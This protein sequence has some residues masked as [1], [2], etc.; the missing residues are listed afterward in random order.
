MRTSKSPTTWALLAVV[1][2]AATT[3]CR[4]GWGS[5]LSSLS[6][7]KPSKPPTSLSGQTLP[8]PSATVSSSLSNGDRYGNTGSSRV[9]NNNWGQVGDQNNYSQIPQTADTRGL[10]SDQGYASRTG[11]TSSTGYPPS[12]G[13]TSP[14]GNFTPPSSGYSSQTDYGQSTNSGYAPATSFTPPEGYTSPTRGYSPP[15]AVSSIQGSPAGLNASASSFTPPNSNGQNDTFG[16]RYG[17]SGTAT[18]PNVD[19]G[20]PGGNSNYPDTSNFRPELGTKPPYAPG[21]IGR[22][23]D[24]SRPSTAPAASGGYSNVTPS[25]ASTSPYGAPNGFYNTGGT[26]LYGNP[27]SDFGSDYNSDYS[28]PRQ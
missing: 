15:P 7:K 28:R 10:A 18:L 13:I 9:S 16:D 23:V 5:G 14:N 19:S 2:I 12:N 25:G 3:G 24:Y 6:F 26:G 20:Y 11:F 4:G 21:T 1:A 17:A 27:P 22:Q 8:P